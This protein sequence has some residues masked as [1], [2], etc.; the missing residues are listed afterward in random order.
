MKGEDIPG[1][2]KKKKATDLESALAQGSESMSG[3]WQCTVG[4]AA[5]IPKSQLT[6]CEGHHFHQHPSHSWPWAQ[7]PGSICSCATFLAR[8]WKKQRSHCSRYCKCIGAA[9]AAGMEMGA[10]AGW[11]CCYKSM[12]GNLKNK[13]PVEV[14]MKVLLWLIGFPVWGY[15]P[16]ISFFLAICCMLV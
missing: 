15:N 8:F 9:V 3:L 2:K 10:E 6:R 13:L 12:N 4:F 14:F 5:Q 1:E 7:A 11:S 16:R